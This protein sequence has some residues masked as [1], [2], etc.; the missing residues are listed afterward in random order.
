MQN[1]IA[2]V[3][4]SCKTHATNLANVHPCNPSVTGVKVYICSSKVRRRGM[5][6]GVDKSEPKGFVRREAV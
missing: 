3:H 5:T 2:K 6:P 1:G 4:G